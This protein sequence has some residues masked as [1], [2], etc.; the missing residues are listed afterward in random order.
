MAPY[1]VC[2]VLTCTTTFISSYYKKHG[3][4]VEF[5]FFSLISIL[6]PCLL[7]AL[8]ANTVGTD[9]LIYGESLFNNSL[10]TSFYEFVINR[11]NEWLYYFLVYISSHVFEDIRFQYFFI[12]LLT[13]APIYLTLMRDKESNRYAWL[14]LWVYFF[15]LFP[16]SLNLMRQSIAISIIFWAFKY[17]EH[18]CLKKYVICVLI[19]SMFHVTALIGIIIYPLYYIVTYSKKNIDNRYS[20]SDNKNVRFWRI[21]KKYG[22]Y[23]PW[24]VAALAVVLLFQ[25][26][27]LVSILNYFD[28]E[29]F[30]T[31]YENMSHKTSL[32]IIRN[33]VLIALP[34]FALYLLNRKYYENSDKQLR[35]CFTFSLISVILYQAAMISSQTYR[36][37]LY[38]HIFWP[39]FIAKYIA[40]T[41]SAKTRFLYICLVMILSVLFWY[42]FFVKSGWCEIIPYVMR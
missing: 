7:A 22:R 11:D 9:M 42:I 20:L 26:S 31:Y 27:Q 18:K 25:Y 6:L 5:C 34:I 4:R 33:Y 35:A 21:A 41:K 3:R 17:V 1:I 23:I 19:A 32:P 14:G 38:L 10:K 13:F 16:Y 15:W 37:S 29:S 30:G 24:L 2:F 40:K 8:R 12:E 36:I 28:S 39:L